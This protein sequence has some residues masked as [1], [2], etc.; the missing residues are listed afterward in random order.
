MR[1]M[2]IETGKEARKADGGGWHFQY[3]SQGE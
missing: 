1:A 2:K 3:H